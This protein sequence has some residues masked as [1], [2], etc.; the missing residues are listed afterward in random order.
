MIKLVVLVISLA[1][2]EPMA[3]YT[4]K[5]SFSTM[6]ACTMFM[7]SATFKASLDE[8]RAFVAEEDDEPFTVVANCTK[9]GG[10]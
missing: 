9:E 1:T 2:H 8:L 5:G 3:A 7:A 6:E 10:A 4:Y